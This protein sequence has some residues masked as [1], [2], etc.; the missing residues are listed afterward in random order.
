MTATGQINSAGNSP[1]I[2][3][4]TVDMVDRLRSLVAERAGWREGARAFINQFGNLE[5][6]GVEGL[7]REDLWKL[8]AG[9]KAFA[10]TGVPSVPKPESEEQWRSLRELTTLL[11]DRSRSPGQRFV[12][13]VARSRELIGAR[14]TQPP[15]VMRVLMILAGGRYGTIVSRSNINKLLDWADEPRLDLSDPASVDAALS[16]MERLAAEWGERLGI[17]DLVERAKIPWLLRDLVVSGSG[18]ERLTDAGGTDGRA[19]GLEAVREM[20]EFMLPDAVARR[21]C[22]SAFADA[23]GDCH[24]GNPAGWNTSVRRWGRHVQLN[25]GR[26]FCAK[27]KPNKLHLTLDEQSLPAGWREQFSTVLD[28]DA[29]G[30]R[31]LEGTVNIALPYE[32][33]EAFIPEL[34]EARRRLIARAATAIRGRTPYHRS[35]AQA[36]IDYLTQELDREVPS[37]AYDV[38]R[39]EREEG[40]DV[41]VFEEDV[42]DLLETALRT[43]N[44]LLFG[45][46]GTGK[47]YTVS[48]FAEAFLRLQIATSASVDAHRFDV[49][50]RL[51]WYEA[52]ALAMKLDGRPRLSV[53]E[54]MQSRLMREFIATRDVKMVRQVHWRT[55]GEHTAPSST[56]VQ[57][58]AKL[59][60]YL[61]DKSEDKKWFLTP[62]GEAYVT[63][64]L[65]EVIEE[66]ERPVSGSLNDFLAFVTFHQ[67]FAYE[68]FV[69]GLKPVISEQDPTQISYAVVPGV[70]RS[71][72]AKAEAAW[73][74]S[75]EHPP[76]FLL[77]IDEINR[78]NIAKVLGELITLIE[79]DKR[80]GQPGELTVTL[81]YSK[82]Q[83]GV[84]PN[85]YV[86]GTMNTADRSIALL[87]IALRR[88]F[89]FVEMMPRPELLT[90]V[91][92]LDLA[93]LLGRLNRRI[94]ALLD[95]DHQ[96]G[97]SYL[98]SVRDVEDLRFAWE[99]RI[100]P[101][102][103]EY[104]HNDSERLRAVLGNA[105][106]EPAATDASLF[107]EIPDSYDENQD[108]RQ[109]REGMDDESLLAA[110]H[111]IAGSFGSSG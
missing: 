92:G 44:L 36:V 11:A 42:S 100:V 108:G 41:P 97:H 64:E 73:R 39:S 56:T 50:S 87:D 89:T 107:D 1:A 35:H 17:A 8:W 24:R 105:F 6:A 58:T 80:L 59:E 38:G 43:R 104:F 57:M 91:E 15:N 21:A 31:S 3:D 68:D 65:S 66:L 109:L 2:S 49:L 26:V 85:L 4:A 46:P 61:F 90:T 25:V 22:L 70:F 51:V 45:P 27:I 52:I 88:R 84:P 28:H 86:V 101:L 74:S 34:A 9:S 60:P 106:F 81:P 54:I 10:S 55:L 19:I 111:R 78:A 29:E 18:D 20:F 47:T 40:G 94:A 32:Q 63:A 95:R 37:P 75:P 12:D 93:K 77:V 83:F 33:L 14:Q 48:R 99:R 98:L 71:I 7:A 13:A 67:S 102:L 30:F 110:L 79:D 69:E 103:R 76:R 5:P 16:V 82:Q 62:A 96:I 23:I 53:T 72:C